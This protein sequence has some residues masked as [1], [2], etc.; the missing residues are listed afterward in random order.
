MPLAVAI[1]P[2]TPFEQNC[3]FLFDEATKRGVIVDPGGDVE[4]ILEAIRQTGVTVETILLTHGH[5]L[6]SSQPARFEGRQGSSTVLPRVR[7][8]GESRTTS[9]IDSSSAPHFVQSSGGVNIFVRSN[10]NTPRPVT[11]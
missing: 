3:A 6:L 4:T 8:S 7:A 1:L 2:V 9:I 5:I 11:S 10:A